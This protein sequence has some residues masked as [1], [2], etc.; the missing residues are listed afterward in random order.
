MDLL[1]KIVISLLDIRTTKMLLGFRFSGYLFD[2]GWFQSL[3]SRSPVDSKFQPLPW[4]TYSFIDFIQERLN[5]EL[6]LFEY[7]SG[8]STHYY[9]RYVKKVWSAE[10]DLDWFSK[11]KEKMPFNAELIYTSLEGSG[12][13]YAESITIPNK[14]FDVVI[15]D[16][17]KR[18][19]CLKTAVNF[20]SPHGVLVLD[21]SERRDY[22]EGVQ[23]LLKLG[24][25]KI[26]FFGVS[27]GLF[28]KKSTT[29]FYRN[30]NCL[31]I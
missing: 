19:L 2:Q 7:G 6:N 3:K 27:P 14:K 17:R 22:I 4:V 28:Y 9:S 31:N 21:D 12:D 29:V 13:K 15:V 25:R 20:L 5:K 24:F 16:G 8:Q 11:V 30:D 23:F 1:K 26:D 10:H 18:N